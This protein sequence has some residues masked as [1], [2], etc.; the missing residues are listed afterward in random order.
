MSKITRHLYD[1][2]K[3]IDLAGKL[4]LSNSTASS[5][6]YFVRWIKDQKEGRNPVAQA[7]PW[8]NYFVIDFLSKNLDRNSKVFEYGG[9]GSTIFFLK[10]IGAD[11]VV[12]VEHDPVWFLRLQSKVT[13]DGFK[14]WKG[15]Q[16]S[17]EVGSAGTDISDP[18]LYISDDQAYKGQNFR[19]YAS[20]ID[21]FPNSHFD[22]VLVDGRARPSCMMHALSKIK[23]GGL[24]LLDN[25]DRAY[26]LDKTKKH[27]DQNFELVLSKTGPC[28]YTSEFTTS[29]IWRKLA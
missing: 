8:M 24:L 6:K 18:S 5:W 25:A 15:I 23:K 7:Y 9:G 16:E 1:F 11:E 27:V 2:K 17:A 12:T 20:A 26:Y 3:G 21:T 4:N 13:S 28:P 14:S 29:M 22:L 19:T 10:R